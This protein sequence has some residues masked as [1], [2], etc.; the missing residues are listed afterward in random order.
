MPC[1]SVA[2]QTYLERRLFALCILATEN[3]ATFQI[4]SKDKATID[5]C[6]LRIPQHWMISQCRLMYMLGVGSALLVLE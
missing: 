1:R 2:R 5:V 6:V 4:Y 3:F